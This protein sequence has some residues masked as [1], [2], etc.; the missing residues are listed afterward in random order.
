VTLNDNHTITQTTRLIRDRIVQRV[1][2]TLQVRNWEYV[3]YGFLLKGIS[4]DPDM[5]GPGLNID[6]NWR[7][8]WIDALVREGIL[9]RELVAHRHN[10]EDLVPVILLP[11]DTSNIGS[12]N[13]PALQPISPSVVTETDDFHLEDMMRRV[14]VSIEQFTSFRG[15]EWCPLGSL[16]KRLRSFDPGTNFQRAVEILVAQGA[17]IIGE[18]ENPQSLYRTKGISLDRES[19]KV[20][21]FLA[22]RDDLVRVLLH[23]YQQH[24]PISKQAIQGLI[25]MAPNIIDTW[26]SIMEVENVLNLVPGHQ[27]LYSL[28]RTHHTVNLVAEQYNIE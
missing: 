9:V 14:V 6:D 18:Y 19:A 12:T 25:T 26:I 27:D 15:F 4:M 22:E 8:D 3:N 17:V 5:G 16:H 20:H 1:A 23:L 24:I 28:F 10:P 11:I 2:N 21:E 7:S 13:I